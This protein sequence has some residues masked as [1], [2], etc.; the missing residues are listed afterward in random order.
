MNSTINHYFT[1]DFSKKIYNNGLGAK[2]NIPKAKF[3]Q[4]VVCSGPWIPSTQEFFLFYY[5]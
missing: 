1:I 3:N 2:E 5:E 4:N